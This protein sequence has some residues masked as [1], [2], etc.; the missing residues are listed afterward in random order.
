MG[1][2]TLIKVRVHPLQPLE[3]CK[4]LFS[5]IISLLKCPQDSLL[6]ASTLLQL[7]NHGNW[8]A[9][10][11]SF[12]LQANMAIPCLFLKTAPVLRLLLV[13]LMPL[14]FLI[15]IFTQRQRFKFPSFPRITVKCSTP[16]LLGVH[17]P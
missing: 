9:P 15:T 5:Y 7:S 4:I 3:N 14:S 10:V 2:L 16:I 13:L 11:N 6:T 1:K 8:V 17:T 12:S